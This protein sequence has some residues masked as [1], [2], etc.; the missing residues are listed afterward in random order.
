MPGESLVSW[1]RTLA[2]ALPAWMLFV[3]ACLGHAF[4]LT[5]GLNVIYGNALPRKVLKFTRKI[6]IL[7]ILCG[8]LLFAYALD[9]FG[10]QQLRW[11][12]VHV[13]LAPYTVL[14][15]IAGVVIGPFAQVLYWLRRTPP[16]QLDCRGRVV[17]VAMELGYP[18]C[19]SV[20]QSP[21]CL[22]PGNQVFQV[23][24][25]QKTLALPQLR[26]AWDGLTVL[27]LSDLHLCGTP[28]RAFFQHVIELCMRDGLPDLVAVTGDIADSAWHHRWVLPVLGRLRWN[29]AGLAILGNHDSWWEVEAIRRRLRRLGMIVLGNSWRQLE[30]RGQPMVVI[31]HEGPW[32]APAPDLRDCPKD[33]FRLC[34]SHTPDNLPWARREKIDLVLAGHV[35]GGQIRFPLIGA[36]F[37]P[38]RYSRRYDCGTFYEMPTLMHVSRGLA[39]QHP[40][41]ILCRPE[42]TRLVLKKAAPAAT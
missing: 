24:F 21:A 3:G 19:G 11:G 22:L 41:R 13:L 17:D 4:L 26:A 1:L 16:H 12:G 39:G 14:C 10:S 36:T 42:V 18:P 32:F 15:F 38:S 37:V 23:E 6:D 40:L 25:N 28:D 8:P 31:G 20:R 33:M 9:I 2:D 29:V 35:H 7:T 27:H 5:I 34:L 30:V